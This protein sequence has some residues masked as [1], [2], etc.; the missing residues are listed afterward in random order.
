MSRLVL[1]D[2][3]DSFTFNLVQR[4]GELGARCTVVRNDAVDLQGL[5]R[6]RPDRLVISPGPCTPDQAGISIDAIRAFAGE[7]PI[8]GVCLGHQSIAQAFGGRVVRA[9]QPVHGKASRVEHDGTSLFRGLPTPLE[10][11]RYHSLV[12]ER[13]TLPEELEVTAW[14]REGEIMALRHRHHPVFGLQFHPE[15]ILTPYG[16]AL[17][18]AFLEG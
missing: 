11:G 12:V 4:L 2:N 3:Y 1:V 18:R 8:L 15:S 13:R 7:V 9:R 16:S 6:L 5:R 17:L 10:A 14:T